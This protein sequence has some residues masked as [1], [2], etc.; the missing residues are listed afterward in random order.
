MIDGATKTNTSTSY[1]TGTLSLGTHYWKVS[2][3]DRALNKSAFSASNSFIVLTNSV[4]TQYLAPVQNLRGTSSQNSVILTWTPSVSAN[5]QYY[6]VLR[7]Q[8]GVNSAFIQIAATVTKNTNT[9]K[10]VTVKCGSVYS[11]LIRTVGINSNQIADSA[12]ITV[13]PTR[14]AK[15]NDEYQCEVNHNK[16]DKDSDNVVITCENKKRQKVKI[17]V[18]NSENQVVQNLFDGDLDAGQRAITWDLKGLKKIN[19]PSG[20]YL[21]V[22]EGEGWRQIKKIY[23]VK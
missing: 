10:D 17:R 9:F 3:M 6:K 1:L 15:T 19:L 22:T 21:I 23:V 20:I 7:K 18:F 11:Y 13:S 14:M 12:I 5:A 4:V 16:I 8:A 2:A